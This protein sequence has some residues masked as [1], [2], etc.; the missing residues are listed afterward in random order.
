[1]VGGEGSEGGGGLE[2]MKNSLEHSEKVDEKV[3]LL[4][5]KF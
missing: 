2:T 4:A 5:Y 3:Y 1:M